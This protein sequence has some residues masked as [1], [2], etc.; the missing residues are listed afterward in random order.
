MGFFMDFTDPE[1]IVCNLCDEP[2]GTC[3]DNSTKCLS[4]DGSEN[5]YYLYNETCFDDCPDFTAPDL[6]SLVCVD[7][8]EHCLQCGTMEGPNCYQCQ[9]PYLLEDGLC[10][11]E[12]TKTGFKPNNELTVCVN[13]IYFPVIGPIFTGMAMICSIITMIIKCF[14]RET[15]VVTSII[16]FVG[17]C[18]AMAIGFQIFLCFY[19][20]VLKYFLISCIAGLS[21]FLLNVT[22]AIY[23]HYNVRS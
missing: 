6:T 3:E 5:R 1:Y 20:K 10:V 8:S 13:E 12:C 16:A 21:L 9:K 11:L 7:C 18:E 2:C 23:I 19:Y 15:K 4:C 14:R 17:I 22:N